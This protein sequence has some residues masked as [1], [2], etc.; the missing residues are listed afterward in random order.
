ML[1]VRITKVLEEFLRLS[2]DRTTGKS[3]YRQQKWVAERRNSVASL[4]SVI[5][6]MDMAKVSQAD[7][8]A[9]RAH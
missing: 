6:D 1:P 2:A 9:F 5:A 4:M 8:E 3:E 7:A